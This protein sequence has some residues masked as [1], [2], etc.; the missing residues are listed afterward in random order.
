MAQRRP[1]PLFL[2]RPLHHDDSHGF[3]RSTAYDGVTYR[4]WRSGFCTPPSINRL[5][6]HDASSRNTNT[7]TALP[8]PFAHILRLY[9][10]DYIYLA[11]P[12]ITYHKHSAANID[13]TRL[14]R[15]SLPSVTYN[16]SRQPSAACFV[17][18]GILSQLSTA[19]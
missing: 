1:D 18:V 19:G 17:Y 15:H 6:S 3:S 2:V 11:S 5:A 12:S 16:F 13:P 7:Y 10:L 8:F 4:I 9:I 14:M